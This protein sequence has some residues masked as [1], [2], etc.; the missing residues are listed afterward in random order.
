[1][2]NRRQLGGRL[3]AW[4]A[5]VTA[6][7]RPKA[8]KPAAEELAIAMRFT[9][10]NKKYGLAVPV[11]TASVEVIDG[12]RFVTVSDTEAKILIQMLEDLRWSMAE[13]MRMLHAG[14]KL[15]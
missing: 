9:Y 6:E 3:A 1:M 11:P 12:C 7:A 5:G 13:S 4:L 10:Q 14:E 8:K 2:M 15:G